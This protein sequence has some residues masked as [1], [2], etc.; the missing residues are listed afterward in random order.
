[1][2]YLTTELKYLE[3]LRQEQEYLQDNPDAHS[4]FDI[5]EELTKSEKLITIIYNDFVEKHPNSPEVY[6]LLYEAV[7]R[8]PLME[9]TTLARK[10]YNAVLSTKNR[11]NDVFTW[12][13]ERS[14]DEQN[15]E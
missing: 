3:A 14:V 1:M 12:L 11:S 4:G 5:D 9:A 8:L 10:A 2:Q 6:M 13:L 15:T 7:K